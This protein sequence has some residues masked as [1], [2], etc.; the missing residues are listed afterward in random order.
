MSLVCSTGTTT[1][2]LVDGMYESEGRVEVISTGFPLASICDSLWG[3]EDATVICKYLNY[4]G[5]DLALLSGY[6][7]DAG[8]ASAYDE[9]TCTGLEDH[10]LQCSYSDVGSECPHSGKGAG[11]TCTAQGMKHHGSNLKY[12][13]IK[14]VLLR[15]LSYTE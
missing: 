5:A 6:F 15:P 4:T 2:R 10:L 7:G 11:V 12:I 9:V 8:N 1:Y 13:Y 3:I 14:D